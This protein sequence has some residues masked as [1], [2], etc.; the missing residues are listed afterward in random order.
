M[1]FPRSP[2]IAAAVALVIGAGASLRSQDRVLVAHAFEAT[3]HG[4][5]VSGDSGAVQPQHHVAGGDPGGYLS[6]EDEALG[7]TW[8]FR[9]PDSVLA[10][11]AAAEHGTLTYSLKQSEPVVGVF[12][13]DVVIIGPAGRLSYRFPYS[14]GT[15]WN[16]FTVRLTAAAGW[17]WNWNA[18]ATQEQIRSVLANPTSLEIRGEYHTGPDEGALDTVELRAGH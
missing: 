9:A 12:E 4:W 15:A 8:Y 6:Y 1:S 2:I 17:R 18:A 13:D 7:E 11:L 14:P 5:L 16:T 3:T 10:A